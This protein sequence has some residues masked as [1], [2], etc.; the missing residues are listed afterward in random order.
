MQR[1]TTFTTELEITVTG[2]Q[3]EVRIDGRAFAGI[4][5]PAP[6][7]PEDDYAVLGWAALAAYQCASKQA[8]RFMPDDVRQAN[9]MLAQWLCDGCPVVIK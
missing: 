1:T 3:L 5:L 8:E 2:Q 7:N 4:T 6:L 9:W